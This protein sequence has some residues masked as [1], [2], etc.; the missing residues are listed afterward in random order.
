MNNH[1]QFL[2]MSSQFRLRASSWGAACMLALH[3]VACHRM[4]TQLPKDFNRQSFWNA[5]IGGS[6][7]ET[8]ESVGLPTFVS[9]Y[10]YDGQPGMRPTVLTNIS[11]GSIGTVSRQLNCYVTCRYSRQRN[12]HLDYVNF[13][14]SFSGGKLTG[15]QEALVTE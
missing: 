8:L 6:V 14:L 11:I 1:L 3:C 13:S 9:I 10:Y 4:G 5:S 7:E 2:Y 12:T 15:K